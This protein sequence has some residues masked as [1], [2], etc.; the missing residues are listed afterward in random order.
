M[1]DLN[2]RR[3]ALDMAVI[4]A[5]TDQKRPKAMEMLYSLGED[6]CEVLTPGLWILQ[7]SDDPLKKL[8]GLLAEIGF[9]SVLDSYVDSTL[10]PDPG[11]GD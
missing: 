7:D 9:D 2:P 3:L 11:S 8:I 6:F 5:A 1:A 10:N 4:R